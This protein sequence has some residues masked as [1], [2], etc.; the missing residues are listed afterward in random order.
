[1]QSQLVCHLEKCCACEP[2][3][4]DITVLEKE[5][6]PYKKWVYES[7]T[8]SQLIAASV[9]VASHLT[10]KQRVFLV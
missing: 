7:H 4:S 1:M 2:Q 3:W 10:R 8:S 5:T 9:T 6:E